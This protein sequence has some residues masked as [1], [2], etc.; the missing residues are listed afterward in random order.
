M[1][2]RSGSWK[3]MNS[4]SQ[5]VWSVGYVGGLAVGETGAGEGFKRKQ[6]AAL[7]TLMMREEGEIAD[8][9]KEII[10]VEDVVVHQDPPDISSKFEDAAAQHGDHERPG[11]LLDPNHRL[12]EE[13]DEEESGVEGVTT[14][15]R[16]I[17]ERCIVLGAC[18]ECAETG[19]VP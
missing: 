19:I 7:M 13:D 16:D 17:S 5:L 4:P 18:F 9:H 3:A 14:Q 10:E 8:S 15:V 12:S 1:L 6:G 2:G 11:A